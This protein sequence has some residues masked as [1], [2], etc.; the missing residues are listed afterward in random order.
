MYLKKI[1][2]KNKDKILKI[3]LSSY[4]KKFKTLKLKQDY[5]KEK[6]DISI[7]WLPVIKRISRDFCKNNIINISIKNVL[8]IWKIY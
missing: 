5:L 2:F 8:F 7:Q 3:L 4:L 1:N 6:V